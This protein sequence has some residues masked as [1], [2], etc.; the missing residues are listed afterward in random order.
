[1][2]TI[3]NKKS[4][5]L[6]GVMLLFA[7]HGFI[8]CGKSSG[9]GPQLYGPGLSGYS[10]TCNAMG[11]FG[12]N[13]GQQISRAQGRV[14]H[15]DELDG[16]AN[17]EQNKLM[18]LSLSINMW[19]QQNGNGFGGMG[20]QMMPM[21]GSSQMLMMANL[22]VHVSGQVS[23]S[24]PILGCN[25]PPGN[26]TIQPQSMGLLN[27]GTLNVRLGVNVNGGQGFTIDVAGLNVL[28]SNF[29]NNGGLQYQ[30]VNEARLVGFIS[31][32]NCDN[33]TFRVE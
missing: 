33:T 10:N 32:P 24:A 2:K 4:W 18:D 9:G 22:P 6:E 14:S 16:T 15:D 20:T 5:W 13:P 29:V 1:M 17:K 19:Q 27:F 21:G 31:I 11:C 12:A 26:Y 25:I 23:V 7:V 8:A 28:P 3:K 30:G